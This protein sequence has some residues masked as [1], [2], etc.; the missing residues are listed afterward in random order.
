MGGGRAKWWGPIIARMAQP[1]PVPVLGVND[2]P[3]RVAEEGD[4]DPGN[5]N[6]TMQR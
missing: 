5:D 4:T 1:Q 3:E 2:S 6:V